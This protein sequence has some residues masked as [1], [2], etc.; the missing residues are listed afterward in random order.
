M[1]L[2]VKLGYNDQLAFP[3]EKSGTISEAFSTGTRVTESGYGDARTFKPTSDSTISFEI[4]PDEFLLEKA[5]PLVELQSQKAYS[6]KK[7]LDEYYA[8]GETK[9]QLREAQDKL[10]SLKTAVTCEA[11]P[12]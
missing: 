10:A 8:H 9:K 4:V 1:K 3:A 2:L 12:F 11:S 7:W 5:E 6:E